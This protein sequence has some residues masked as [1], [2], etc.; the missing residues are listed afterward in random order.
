MMQE[1]TNPSALQ[2]Q[3]SPRAPITDVLARDRV[4]QELRKL[5]R[6][7]AAVIVTC[8]LAALAAMLSF[9]GGHELAAL[10][11]LATAGAIASYFF[12]GPVWTHRPRGRLGPDASVPPRPGLAPKSDAEA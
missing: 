5:R 4:A 11:F 10:C 6:R 3:A 1:L 12:L 8:A 9:A 2:I 7:M